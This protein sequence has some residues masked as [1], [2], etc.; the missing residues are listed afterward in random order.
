MEAPFG[1]E[2]ARITATAR[3]TK[4]PRRR[5]PDAVGARPAAERNF[6]VDI[7]DLLRRAYKTF[8]PLK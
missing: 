5:L 6:P 2:G 4:H 1:N 7:A 3:L 8:I